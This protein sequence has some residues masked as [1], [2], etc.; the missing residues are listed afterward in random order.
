MKKFLRNFIVMAV[1]FALFL[2]IVNE[3]Q[4]SAK[5]SPK[6]N[7][8]KVTIEVGGTY[9]LKVTGTT[10][11]VKWSSTNK[12][13]ATVK[14]GKVT[15]KSAGKCT[16]KAKVS[17]KTLKC[18][19]TVKAKTGPVADDDAFYS[20]VAKMVKKADKNLNVTAMNSKDIHTNRVI[21]GGEP[22]L[23]GI[24]PSKII[25]TPW[26]DHI[27][28]FDDA[29]T[30]QT[31]I[32]TQSKNK[33]VTFVEEDQYF[34][35]D[36]ISPVSEASNV[37]SWGTGYIEADAF[38][39]YI[40]SSGSKREVVVAIIDT[41]AD[42]DHEFLKGRFVSKGYDLVDGDNDASDKI[43]GHGTHVS[44]TIVDCTP[45]LPVKLLEIR[46]LDYTGSGTSTAVSNGIRYAIKA[47]ANVINMSLGGP[48]SACIDNA[49]ASAVE[50]GITV[51][52]AAGNESSNAD[53]F[54]PSHN[55]QSIVVA[56]MDKY[57]KSATFTNYGK[58]V[59]LA[60]PGVKI[61][62]SIPNNKYADYN[63]TS[64]ATPHVAAAAAMVKM[65]YPSYSPE[66]VENALKAAAKDLGNPGKDDYFGNGAL[67]LGGLIPDEATSISIASKPTKDYYYVND[68]LE[69]AGLELNV[70]YKSGKTERVSSGFSCS[71]TVLTTAGTQ[72]ITV[73]YRGLTTTFS[74]VVYNDDLVDL[75][76]S[77]LP[78]KLTYFVG[79]TLD[80]TGLVLKATTVSGK[81]STVTTGFTCSPTKLDFAGDQTILVTYGGISCSF[82]VTVQSKEIKSISI[83]SLPTKK[84][85]FD[86]DT[87]DTTGLV[88]K[89]E[90]TDGEVK[91]INSGFT[92]TPTYLSI[93]DVNTADYS[94]NKKIT[95]YYENFTTEFVVLVKAIK[96]S[97]LEVESL[98]R[99]TYY[100]DETISTKDV[101][102]RVYYTN[103][104]SDLVTE[105]FTLEPSKLTKK[106]EQ[107]VTATFAGLSTTFTVTV[108]DATVSH[109]VIESLPTKREYEVGDTLD[110]T[111]LSVG[112]V[113]TGGGKQ[114]ITEGFSWT[115]TKLTTEG[116]QTITVIYKDM[117]AVF[118]VTVKDSAPSDWVPIS[119]VPDGA[120]IVE[121]KWVYDFTE[122]TESWDSTLD[123]WTQTG[124]DW[125]STGSGSTY[126]ASFPSTFDTGHSIYT[127]F[128]KAPYDAYENAT[129]K[130]TVS[131][132]FAGYVYWHWMYS[133]NYANNTQRAISD[134]YG[135]YD[136]YGKTPGF[137]Y[138]YFSAFCSSVD[139]PYLDNYYC[140]SRNQ[141]S[142]NC[143]NIMPD[144]SSMGT[145]T[146]R[147]FRFS[148][149]ESSYT[150]YKKIFFYS[151]TTQKESSTEVTEGNGIS[152]VRVY[153]KYKK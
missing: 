55:K 59:D 101:A 23:T 84:E 54:C 141:P 40:I 131:N 129:T 118:E 35:I 122:K 125:R 78:N 9:T 106:G 142:Y 3:I 127:S 148:Y 45:N 31:F 41:G 152:N 53:N 62:S 52:V 29:L 137:M 143:V 47:G 72:S 115:P 61:H 48:H 97:K 100:L 36:E 117:A 16:I 85:Y 28:Q 147:Y 102:L 21:V 95:V 128:A 135:S 121:K 58:N 111:G 6:L 66:D 2:G 139:A 138:K 145:G 98:A 77:Q 149:N 144:K 60:A 8:K 74:V 140:C 34:V 10:A 75:E 119:D 81:T 132:K 80:T 90:Y 133:V 120:Q 4:V 46:V 30:A 82:I 124:S 5:S 87:L 88:L 7:K 76:V 44:G 110:T 24:D 51:C 39:D 65:L 68:T 146:P 99:K 134:R 22:D 151:K 109:I 126:Y 15:A 150:D 17:G 27:I 12:K 33:K 104:K 114:V 113:Y 18:K 105:G 14:N 107:T 19:V 63:G 136:Q 38:A 20:S 108:E 79:D 57:E 130:R 89:A 64:M 13:I 86:G 93:S 37:G 123:G 71:P 116:K 70:Q 25:E 42:F 32:S 67:K 103:G 11:K 43:Q 49:I 91:A 50:A 153:V 56:A 73:S 112:V 96:A 94:E 26:G 92:C 1:A 69:T 83:A